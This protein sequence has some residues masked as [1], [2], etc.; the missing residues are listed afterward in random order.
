M[1]LTHRESES[2]VNTAD[3]AVYSC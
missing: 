2:H 1:F 3:C